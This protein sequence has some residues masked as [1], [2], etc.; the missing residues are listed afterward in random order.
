MMGRQFDEYYD[1]M[2]QK[3]SWGVRVQPSSPCG[4]REQRIAT[5]AIKLIF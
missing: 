3:S 1:A 2:D 5:V 4:Q